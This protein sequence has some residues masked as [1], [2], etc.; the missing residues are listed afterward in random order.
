MIHKQWHLNKSLFAAWAGIVILLSIVDI[1]LTGL[2]IN[3]YTVANDSNAKIAVC[4][5]FYLN[6]LLKENFRWLF[7]MA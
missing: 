7:V 4:L 6:C 2:L 3:D 5:N 1:V